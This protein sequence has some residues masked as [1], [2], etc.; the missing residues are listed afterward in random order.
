MS[1][2]DWHR[3][4]WLI[5]HKASREEILELLAIAER[6]LH[7]CLARGLSPDWQLAIAYNSALQSAAAALAAAGY[8]SAREAYHFRVIKSLAHT[9]GAESGLIAKL[10]SFRKLRNI[11]D[12]QKSGTVSAHEAQE[13][14]MLAKAIKKTV[15]TWLRAEHP[16][17]I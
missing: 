9:V 11:C 12:Y 7:D 16:D 13:M 8:L 3:N 17:L 4:G 6:D 14:I 1:L 15:F 2:G 10:D 5:S